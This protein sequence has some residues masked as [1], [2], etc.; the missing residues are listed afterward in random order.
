MGFRQER[1]RKREIEG[2]F[3]AAGSSVADHKFSVSVYLFDR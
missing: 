2:F 3:V 1:Q